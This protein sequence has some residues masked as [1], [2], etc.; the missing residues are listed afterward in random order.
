[1][2]KVIRRMIEWSFFGVEDIEYDGDEDG[3]WDE[4]TRQI[5]RG[6]ELKQGDI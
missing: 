3:D 6:E 1:M 4:V 2:H 5:D